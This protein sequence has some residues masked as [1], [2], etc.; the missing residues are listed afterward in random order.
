V[1]ILALAGYQTPTIAN[2][3]RNGVYQYSSLTFNIGGR[4][5]ADNA[6]SFTFQRQEDAERFLAELATARAI[7]DEAVKNRDERAL[8]E[9][10][11]FAPC[12]LSGVW[13]VPPGAAEGGPTVVERPSWAGWARWLGALVLGGAVSLTLFSILKSACRENPSCHSLGRRD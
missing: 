5:I 7:F 2:H 3:L 13:E 11:P 6:F 9:I 8:R 10:D 12:T 1:K 4:T